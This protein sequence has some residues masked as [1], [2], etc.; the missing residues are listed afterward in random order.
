MLLFHNQCLAQNHASAHSL[1]E[2]QGRSPC[3]CLLGVATLIH[4]VYENAKQIWGR[5][6]LSF[7]I[8]SAFGTPPQNKKVIHVVQRPCL[9]K[10]SQTLSPATPTESQPSLT[11]LGKVHSPRFERLKKFL[12]WLFAVEAKIID[13]QKSFECVL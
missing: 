1:F 11:Y 7:L 10:L 4:P 13:K 2:L 5:G 9:E 3:T 12:F 6:A 8:S